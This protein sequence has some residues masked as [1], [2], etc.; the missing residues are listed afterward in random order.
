MT[1]HSWKAALVWS[2]LR[3][4]RATM[5]TFRWTNWYD[6]RSKAK[7]REQAVKSFVKVRSQSVVVSKIW[8]PVILSDSRSTVA[9]TTVTVSM[10]HHCMNMCQCHCVPLIGTPLAFASVGMYWCCWCQSMSI[11]LYRWPVYI[12][13]VTDDTTS[14]RHVRIGHCAHSAKNQNN[15]V[16]TS[17]IEY[18]FRR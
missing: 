17:Y 18:R 5:A 7:K 2:W 10:W 6:L 13:T 8:S 11:L 15:R 12:T 4:C 9:S 14:P 1:F 3:D 16:M